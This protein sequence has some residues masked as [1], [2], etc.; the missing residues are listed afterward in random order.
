[1]SARDRVRQ[2]SSRLGEEERGWAMATV[3]IVTT[4]MVSVGLATAAWVDGQTRAS[5]RERLKE[6][7]FNL[8]EGALNAQ[9]YILAHAWPASNATMA[10]AYPASCT[11]AS[12]SPLCPDSRQLTQSYNT[13]DY[14]GTPTWT[15]EIHDNPGTGK[16]QCQRTDAAAFY[17]DAAPSANRWDYNCDRKLWVRAQATVNG[18]TRAIVGLVQIELQQE[19]LPRSALVAGSVTTTNNGNKAIICTRLPDDPTGA[20]CASSSPLAG[21]VQVRCDPKVDGP[22]CLNYRT[23]QVTPDATVTGYTGTGLSADAV[24][25]L[26]E[27]SISEGTYYASGCPQTP[28]GTVGQ[29]P[30]GSIIFV[31]NGNCAYT[32]SSPTWP[33]ALGWNTAADPGIY[34]VNNGTVSFSGNQT[35]FGV[36]YA[37]NAQGTVGC[38]PACPVSISGTGA[39]RGGI[40][41]GGKGAF[42]AGSS[43]VNLLF[44]DYA[45]NAMQSYGAA[46][47][48]QNRW[49][50]IVPRPGS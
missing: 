28:A 4:L 31:E 35:F 9:M 2:L 6:S 24:A 33:T 32:N 36:I 12:T 46:N 14:S 22:T 5:G 42:S 37:L 19:E 16:Q 7:S 47:L 21:P 8:A 13:A 40:Q 26:R 41:V 49:R 34:I 10:P 18:R 45:F 25:R 30:P 17:D 39:V 27:R 29:T 38:N 11:Q 3:I 48:V 1:M 23:G 50:E 43:K 20:T 44:D 15:T